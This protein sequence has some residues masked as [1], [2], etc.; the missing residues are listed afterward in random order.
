MY[1]IV[2]IGGNQFKVEKDNKIYVD[3]LK[4]EEGSNIEFDNVLLVAD[5][6]D[7]KVGNPLVEGAK[8]KAKVLEHCKA[9]KVLIF[10]KKRR[11]GHQVL[12]GHRQQVTQIQVEDLTI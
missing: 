12:N 2:E 9:D 1:A 4:E 3:K 11:K 5:G 6:K 7:I 10:R 8:V